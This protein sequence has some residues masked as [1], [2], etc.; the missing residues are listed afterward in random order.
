MNQVNKSRKQLKHNPKNESELDFV[1]SQPKPAV[2]HNGTFYVIKQTD[3][4]SKEVYLDRVEFIIRCIEKNTE[5]IDKIVRLSY[6]WRN[7][8]LYNMSYPNSVLRSIKSLD[9]ME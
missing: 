1:T 2:Y 7:V 9:R 6:V 8:K 3:D 5:D 4:E